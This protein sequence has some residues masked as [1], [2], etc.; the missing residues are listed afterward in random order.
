[1]IASSG[2][3]NWMCCNIVYSLGRWVL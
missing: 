3:S 2:S 1:M